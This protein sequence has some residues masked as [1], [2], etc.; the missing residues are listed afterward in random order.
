M[1]RGGIN[2]AVVLK[3]RQALLARG[4]NPSID[5]VRVELGNTGSKSTIH[6]YLKEIEAAETTRMDDES[7]LS[8]PIRTLITQL[9]SQLKKEADTIVSSAQE[10]ADNKVAT[11]EAALLEQAAHSE[12]L[13]QERD[14]H[15]TM[16]NALTSQLD[17]TQLRLNASEEK[18]QALT[19]S[20]AVST[21]EQARLQAVIEEK[22]SHI[23]SL[24]EKHVHAREA[25]QHYR[26]AVKAQRE[27]DARQQEQQLHTLHRERR[28]LAETLSVKQSE[29]TQLNQENARL[30]TELSAAQQ[31]LQTLTVQAKTLAS[32][33]IEHATLA[34][35]S[36]H[37]QVERDR[38]V[39]QLKIALTEQENVKSAHETL[40]L[41]H[42]RLESEMAVK[43]EW[44]ENIMA[45]LTQLKAMK[46]GTENNTIDKL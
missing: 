41:S 42:A 34:Q 5:A 27:Q 4:E 40:S 29:M 17:A 31:Q 19:Q 16:I 11:M 21:E 12:R 22:Q 13:S 37:L 38:L 28:Q 30:V 9:V 23:E 33:Q 46:S 43:T 1:A 26:E 39:S 36:E 6:R 14:E 25:L 44:L 2:K 10:V 7:L 8:E 32:L 35:S 18:R 3:A 45:E 15:A 20:L 24:E